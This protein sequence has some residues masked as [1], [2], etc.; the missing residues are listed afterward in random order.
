VSGDTLK[1]SAEMEEPKGGRWNRA[2][3]E[4]ERFVMKRVS[5]LLAAGLLLLGGSA[6]RAGEPVAI[7]GTLNLAPPPTGAA[8]SSGCAGP[9]SGGQCHC[10]HSRNLCDWL[11]YK[12]PTCHACCC[13]V[14]S[15]WPPLYTWFLDRCQGCGDGCGHGGCGRGGAT[16]AAPCADG[17]CGKPALPHP[18][19]AHQP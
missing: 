8:G 13:V 9:F 11:L 6:V 5:L 14:S 12:P 1:P 10:R 15:C 2:G 4:R 7:P 17:G 3:T 19:A 16:C 18:P